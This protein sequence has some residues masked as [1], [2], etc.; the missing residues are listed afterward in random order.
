MIQQ[1]LSIPFSQYVYMQHNSVSALSVYAA[2]LPRYLGMDP[3]ADS[4]LLYIAE[5][6]LTAPVPDGWTVHLDSEV[7]PPSLPACLPAW[8]V[9]STRA[10]GCFA[11]ACL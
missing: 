5:W 2:V 10:L 1:E 8:H 4:D 9:A 7:G 6:A 3:D 11:M